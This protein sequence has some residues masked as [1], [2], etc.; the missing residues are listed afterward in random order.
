M[1]PDML[2]D[3]LLPHPLLRNATLRDGCAQTLQTCA[4]GRLH[5]LN[6]IVEVVLA[7]ALSA[8]LAWSAVRPAAFFARHCRVFTPARAT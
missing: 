6:G 7:D 4:D 8:A 3:A 5:M 1:L 2:P